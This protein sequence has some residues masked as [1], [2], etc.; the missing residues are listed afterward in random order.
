MLKKLTA[1]GAYRD[2]LKKRLEEKASA[3]ARVQAEREWII[4]KRREE[5]RLRQRSRQENAERIKRLQAART[6]QMQD[7]MALAYEKMQQQ[8]VRVCVHRR[9]R[10]RCVSVARVPGREQV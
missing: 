10:R 9:R 6:A 8:M 5:Q 7:K 2:D 3:A 4:A 1:R